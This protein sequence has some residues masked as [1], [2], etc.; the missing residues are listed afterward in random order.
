MSKVEW[1]SE[2]VGWVCTKSE[3]FADWKKALLKLCDETNM[4]SYKV[5]KTVE[6]LARKADRSVSRENEP[7]GN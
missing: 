5:T 7:K 4:C 2:S 1:D 6:D 3:N